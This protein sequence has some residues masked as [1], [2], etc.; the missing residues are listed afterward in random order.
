MTCET[1]IMVLGTR[2]NNSEF[3]LF[4]YLAQMYL[5]VEKLVK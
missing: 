5:N 4:L 1:E 3:V 2:V